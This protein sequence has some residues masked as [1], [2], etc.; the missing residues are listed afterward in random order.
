M[1]HN[2]IFGEPL[3]LEKYK[4]GEFTRGAFKIKVN[5]KFYKVIQNPSK[6]YISNKNGTNAFLFGKKYDIKTYKYLGEHQNDLHQ[7]GFIDFDIYK[8]KSSDKEIR[9]AKFEKFYPN[10]EWNNRQ[11]LKK[12]QKEY[13]YVLFMG[14]TISN[15]LDGNVGAGLYTHYD[16]NK[17]ID[18]IIID[19]WH[20]FKYDKNNKKGRRNIREEYKDF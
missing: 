10:W 3:T 16:K 17:D 15:I 19:N 20:F 6:H 11:S 1:K 8:K 4:W 12:L 18:S 14:E 7:T 2:I 13:P 5:D 9:F